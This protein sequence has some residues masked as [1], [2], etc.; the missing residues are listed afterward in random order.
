[1]LKFSQAH[2]FEVAALPIE[3]KD[4]EDTGDWRERAGYSRD[5]HSSDGTVTGEG[6]GVIHYYKQKKGDGWLVEIEN[7]TLFTEILVDNEAEL[8]ALRVKISAPILASISDRISVLTSIAEKAFRVWHEHPFFQP[9]A[10]C[11]PDGWKEGVELRRR[12]TKGTP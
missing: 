8:F 10:E 1:M 3:S 4:G 6:S 11:D 5:H 7:G 12:L 2:G 9:C